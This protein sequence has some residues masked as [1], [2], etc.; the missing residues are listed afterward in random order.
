M[1]LH[2]LND[3][4][5]EAARVEAQ[6]HFEDRVAYGSDTEAMAAAAAFDAVCVE[7]EERR[8]AAS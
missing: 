7:Q 1:R 2:E 4:E 5:L 3:E 6:R 8:R